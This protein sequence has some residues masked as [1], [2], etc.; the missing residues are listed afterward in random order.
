M[1]RSKVKV[2]YTRAALSP[3]ERAPKPVKVTMREPEP[4]SPLHKY[5]AEN[6]GCGLTV[7]ELMEQFQEYDCSHEEWV[8]VSNT[9]AYIHLRCNGCWK[10]KKQLRSPNA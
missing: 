10:C 1:A 9:A 8:V 5:I 7:K 2:S 6:E 3:S 4:Q